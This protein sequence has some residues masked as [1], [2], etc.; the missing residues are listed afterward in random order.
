MRLFRHYIP[1]ALV[2]FALAET[3][4]LLVSA[5][6]GTLVAL[7]A[8]QAST[9]NV[10][11]IPLVVCT[12]TS[13]WASAAVFC[14]SVLTGMVAMGFYQRDQRHDPIEMF[15]RLT[16]SMLIGL[17]ILYGLTLRDQPGG[18]FWTNVVV[19]L[20]IAFIGIT[21]SR[22]L[23]S[24]ATN[25]RFARRVLV[26]GIGSRAHQIEKLRRAADRAGI[27]I[28]GYV[29]SGLDVQVV[30]D[31]AVIRRSGSLRE[32]TDRFSIDEIVVAIDERRKG[33]P[34]NE[35]LECKMNGVSVLE[36]GTF[37]ER[38]LGKIRLD[39][40]QP[41]NIIF[42]DGFTEAVLKKTEKRLLDILLASLLL[43]L[44]LPLMCV[45]AIAIL[46]ESGGPIFY[47][48]SRVG[49]LGKIFE[50]YKFRSMRV[51]AEGDGQ[52]V[53]AQK[54]DSRITRTGRFLRRTR[55][56]ELPQLLNV[57]RGEMS[58]VGPRPERPEFVKDLEA[59]IPYFALRH[60]IKPG[61]TGWAQVSYPYG[62]S[63][64]DALEK[65]QYDLYYLKNY[66]V[67][68]DIN[69]LIQTVQVVL[70]GKGAL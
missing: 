41:S 58:F 65:L 27:V 11:P 37:L 64:N 38:Q 16:L 39:E 62:A 22:L 13:L 7:V 33:L 3:L 52:A 63:V 4:V 53:W 26:L 31:T 46:A 25:V 17:L 45:T 21:T 29:D 40:I 14:L 54:N 36:V 56:D 8:Q 9:G 49:L 51:D 44:A 69:V 55:I 43:A 30:A 15:I 61:I 35:I 34:V 23:C 60:Y 48:Q 57:L 68:L 6:L 2:L 19:A 59:T 42:S 47:R 1:V 67:F 10:Y 66:S 32:L 18:L 20:L 70:W 50:V 28:V 24:D 12:T 5:Y